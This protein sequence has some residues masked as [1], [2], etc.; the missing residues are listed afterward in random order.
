MGKF[1][2]ENKYFKYIG[3]TEAHIG[4]CVTI[5]KG[6]AD[7]GDGASVVY[8]VRTNLGE[9][10]HSIPLSRLE[11]ITSAE[12]TADKQMRGELMGLCG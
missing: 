4:K 6:S 7:L 12:Y 1:L 2:F 5:I 11:Q 10:I 8:N 9:T 3:P